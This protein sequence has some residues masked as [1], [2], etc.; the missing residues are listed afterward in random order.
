[1]VDL[2]VSPVV[3]TKMEPTTARLS[4][5]RLVG[6]PMQSPSDV[7]HWL[8]AVQAQ[9]YHGAEWSIGLRME[10]GTEERVER[11]FT[12]GKIL[13][14][15]VMRPTWHFIDPKDIRWLLELTS[16]RVNA[17]NLYMH[18][19][20]GLEAGIFARASAAIERALEGGNELTRAELGEALARAG[21]SAAGT[22]LTY[23]VMKA[24]LEALVC[25]GPRR[26]KQFTY[27]LLD[28]RVRGAKSLDREEAL[29]ELATRYFTSHGPATLKDFSWW[30]GLA[31]KDAGTG[32]EAA[33]DSL[34]EEESEGEMRWSSRAGRRGT[35]KIHGAL[36]MPTYDELFVGYSSFDSLRRGGK[37]STWDF[38]HNSP[39]VLDGKVGGSWRRKV[40]AREVL[41][42]IA[43]YTPLAS[44]DREKVE[45]AV[46][47]YGR[48][49]SLRATC[50]VKER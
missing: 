24:E 29:K 48:F 37:G 22:R 20:V 50:K 17:R 15:H 34:A 13:R 47:S 5:Q 42:D 1:M 28:E 10:G 41:V 39:L 3:T 25:S 43:P 30:S 19:K 32:L 27:A 2:I 9:D 49:L 38:I 23:L 8:G 26:G 21:I 46:Q 33:R 31:V 11:S 16:S 45:R 40:T 44:E 14:T 18:R 6:H 36:L 4:P 7:V 35:G 12:E